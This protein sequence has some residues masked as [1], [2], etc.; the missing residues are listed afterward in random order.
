ML[1]VKQLALVLVVLLMVLKGNGEAQTKYT[2]I[3]GGSDAVGSLLDRA[4]RLF[5]ETLEEESDGAIKVNFYPAD[6]LGGDIEQIQSTMAGT[7]HVYGDVL[8]WLAN[9]MTDFNI[10]GWGFTFRDKDHFKKF[11]ESDTCKEMIAKFEKQYGVKILGAVPTQPRI[12]FS[13]KPVNSLK[14]MENVKMRV[15][16]IESYLRL[17]EAIGARPTRV[18]WSEVY[19]ALKQGVID[20]CEG[21]PSPAYAAKL[22]EP[23]GNVTVTAHLIS[24]YF[25]MMNGAMYESLGPDLQQK[26]QIAANAALQYMVQ[27]SDKATEEDLNKMEAEGATVVRSIDVKPWQEKVRS[28]T[29]AME[30]KGLWRKGLYDEIQEIQ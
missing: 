13:K 8:V 6:Q 3:F 11:L 29:A 4:N 17:W 12:L 21:P 16:E 20:A 19:M 18:T 24:S 9:W 28:A 30:E 14:D 10:L 27:E 2:L 5:C 26:V 1:R 25:L 22:H 15:P 7:Q 23:T